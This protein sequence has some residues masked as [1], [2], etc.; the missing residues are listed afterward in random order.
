MTSARSCKG[1]AN[2]FGYNTTGVCP[3]IALRGEQYKGLCDKSLGF[4]IFGEQWVQADK[5]PP[6]GLRAGVNRAGEKV[7]LSML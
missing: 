2:E 5:V 6:R 7:L 1:E 4:F 3:A